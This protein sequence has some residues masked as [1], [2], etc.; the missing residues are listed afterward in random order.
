M[1]NKYVKIIS[2]KECQ[3]ITLPGTQTSWSSTDYEHGRMVTE[4]AQK[5]AVVLK[6]KFWDFV[7]IEATANINEALSERVQASWHMANINE[8]QNATQWWGKLL[9]MLEKMY[10][11]EQILLIGVPWCI[12][13]EHCG[14]LESKDELFTAAVYFPIFFIKRSEMKVKKEWGTKG[15]EG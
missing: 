14:A 15:G 7:T 3:I 13:C 2:S 10:L 11:M 4:T 6:T 9:D 8:A 12:V 1:L 5:W